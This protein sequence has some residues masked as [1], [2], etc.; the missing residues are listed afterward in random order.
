[1]AGKIKTSMAMNAF[2][3]ESVKL[4]NGSSYSHKTIKCIANIKKAETMM[5]N[6][7]FI[8]P[9]ASFTSFRMFRL[10]RSANFTFTAGIAFNIESNKP[11]A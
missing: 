10:V 6:Q 4:K 5:K 1:M 2:R 9:L 3:V 7:F 11:S 8:Y